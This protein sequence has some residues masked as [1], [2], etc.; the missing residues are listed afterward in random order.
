ET[1]VISAA[2][3][4]D[5]SCAENGGGA[6]AM[7]ASF[8]AAT[9]PS[10]T[11][12]I[13][14]RTKAAVSGAAT[15]KQA[16][17]NANGTA[18]AL[19][20]SSAADTTTAGSQSAGEVQSLVCSP[21][22]VK[23][24]ALLTCELRV[25][26]SRDKATVLLTSSSNQL[27]TPA[28]VTTRANQ[29]TLTFQAQVA[30]DA[31]RQTAT[32]TASLAGT[33]VRDTI[34]VMPVP[35]PVLSAPETQLVQIGKPLSF[36][37]SATD[38]D[39]APVLVEAK[40]VPAGA[41]FEPDS[42]RF[43]WTPGAGSAGKYN[44]A[45]I[46]TN[47]N[48]QSSTKQV[49]IEVGSGAPVLDKTGQ[50]DCSANA[51]AMLKGK[52]LAEA[53]SELSDASGVSFNLGGTSVTVNGQRVPVLYVSPSRVDTLCPA[54]PIPGT[55]VPVIVKTD[56]GASEAVQ[57]T[58]SD[59]SPRILLLSETGQT[60]TGPRGRLSFYGTDDLVMERN[61]NVSAHPA[62]PGDEIQIRATGLGASPA[63][64]VQTMR[65]RIGDLYT[66]AES[67]EAAPGRPGI[68]LIRLRVPAGVAGGDEAV[69]LQMIS[70]NGNQV[71]SNIVTAAFEAVRQ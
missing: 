48:H 50:N 52:W 46:A 59:A 43:A 13:S 19:A 3:S 45:F 20:G 6:M 39:N 65:V 44:I 55:Q 70:P 32:I 29:S 30:P 54:S 8:K 62:Q 16:S 17:L 37:V 22:T 27:A 33:E 24:D 28:T 10:A 58:E 9:A 60:Q 64:L 41:S 26:A 35:G 4:Y 40:G 15:L 5:A 38:P 21:S 57:I 56:S 69:Q 42:G 61:P 36:T 34:L 11:S 7:M 47:S 71:T 49:E 18:A 63:G 25:T 23:A 31:R 2:G 51:I 67:I 1:K 66:G 68:W 53:G 12:T 14:S